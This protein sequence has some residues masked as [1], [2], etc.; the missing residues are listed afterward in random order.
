MTTKFF[1]VV[2]DN[3][4]RKIKENVEFVGMIGVQNG[5]GLMKMVAHGVQELLEKPTFKDR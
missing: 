4:L 3:N 1:V 2:L 5:P